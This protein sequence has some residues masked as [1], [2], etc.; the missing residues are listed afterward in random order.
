MVPQFLTK[1]KKC[2]IQ[3]LKQVSVQLENVTIYKYKNNLFLSFVFHQTE[4]SLM[5]DI[6]YLHVTI[7]RMSAECLSN[8]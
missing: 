2:P 7:C 4:V 8:I 1:Y 3:R 6:G 5:F